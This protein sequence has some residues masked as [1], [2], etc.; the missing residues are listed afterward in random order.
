MRVAELFAMDE[1]LEPAIQFILRSSTS[2]SYY[3]NLSVAVLDPAFGS[4]LSPAVA[5]S[6]LDD[7]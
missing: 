4:L 3:Y 1:G 2:T 6:W 5:T 7:Y